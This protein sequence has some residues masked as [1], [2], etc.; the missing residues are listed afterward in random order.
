M[1][2]VILD[3][4]VIVSAVRADRGPLAAVIREGWLTGRFQ[5]YVSAP[6]LDEVERTLLKPYFTERI[7]PER[8]QRFLTLIKRTAVIQTISEPVIRVATH[9]E[10]DWILATAQTAHAQFLVTGDKA[11]QGL[12][13]FGST[14]VMTP[15]A[16][17]DYL[18][19]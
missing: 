8:R 11:L 18:E 4:N 7:N 12:G 14:R 9:P 2:R 5:I 6:L 3:T 1:T 16:F 19:S 17:A 13:S 15:T 10:D